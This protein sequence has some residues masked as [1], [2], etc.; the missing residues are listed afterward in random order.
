MQRILNPMFFLVALPLMAAPPA[1]HLFPIREGGKLGFIDRSGKVVVAP[2]YDAV[3]EESEGLI[4]VTVDAKS[5]YIDSSGKL[6]IAPEYD[7]AGE[8][9]DGRAVVRIESQYSL[10]DPTGKRIADIPYRVL[11]EFHQGLLRV[12][13]AGRPT[14]YGFVDR[15][16]RMVVEPQF[17]NAGE[18]SDDPAN[19]N[20]TV[21]D[22]EWCY[23]DRTGKVLI[24]VSMGEDLAAGDL[25]VDGRLRVK[26]GFT[27]GFKDS[28]G[29]WAIP[30]KYNDAKSFKDGLARVQ[31]G[32]KWIAID[33]RGREVPEDKRK[34]RPL[35][36]P[37]EGLALAED[38]DLLGWIDDRG[39]PAFP[40]RKYDEAHR[41]SDGRARIK[42]DSRYGF[43]DPEGSLVIPARYWGA[44]DFDHGL[45]FVQ[46]DQ[47]SAYIDPAGTV[48]WTSKPRPPLKP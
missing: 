7:S 9:R 33:T 11:G 12:Q 13:K 2:R 19:L 36:P 40:F 31:Q 24:R 41:F 30:P 35:E 32:D 28:T 26:D 27:W 29:K 20:A 1:G 44:S 6:V 25:F 34:I 23:F 39:K 46:T 16:G 48:V 43:L 21:I 15:D 38:N 10:I 5:G 37:S 22:R 18:F 17:V 8:F 42:L 47:G 14:A 3:G 45:A 4:R